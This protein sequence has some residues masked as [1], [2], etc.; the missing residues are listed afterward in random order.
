MRTGMVFDRRF[1][2]EEGFEQTKR[3]VEALLE[4]VRVLEPRVQFALRDLM[5]VHPTRTPDDSPV[6]GALEHA[7]DHV[8][9]RRAE[10]IASPGTYDH[11]HVAKIAGVPH[12]VAYGPGELVQAHQPD[13]FTRV[14]DIV[15]ATKVLAMSVM[16]LTGAQ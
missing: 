15:N 13:E 5:V 1:L 14:D 8:L 11:K 6:I 9:G 12:C 2:I 4:S 16:E 7:I 3:D 10:L